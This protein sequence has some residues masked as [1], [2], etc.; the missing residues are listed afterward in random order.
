M[1]PSCLPSSL[2]TRTCGARICPF[3]RVLVLM[4]NLL[5]AT[6]VVLSVTDCSTGVNGDNEWP[7]SQS[8]RR[9]GIGAGDIVVPR[10]YAL[11]VWYL[12]RPGL[13]WFGLA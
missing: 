1:T 3:R 7:Y 11:V 4:L 12:N 2:M 6:F 8:A 13:Q 9:R 10:R 5:Y